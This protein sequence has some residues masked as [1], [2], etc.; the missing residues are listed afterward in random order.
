MHKVRVDG[1]HELSEND[2]DMFQNTN[3]LIVIWKK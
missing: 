3:N 2:G 1:N